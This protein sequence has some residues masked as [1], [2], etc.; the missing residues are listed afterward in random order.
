MATMGLISIVTLFGGSIG[1][2]ALESLRSRNRD[3]INLR[4]V[5]VTTLCWPILWHLIGFAAEG[6]KIMMW[7]LLSLPISAAITFVTAYLTSL[8]LQAWI[9]K[10]K[11]QDGR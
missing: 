6:Q 3:T 9:A 5:V 11:N 1:F 10:S 7:I 4:A 2:C 8:V